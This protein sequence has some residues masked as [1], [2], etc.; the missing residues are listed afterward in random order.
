[1]DRRVLLVDDDPAMLTLL[2]K[3]L[4][5]AEYEVLTARDGQSALQLLHR[6]GPPIVLSDWSMPGMNGLELCQA[7]RASEAIGFVYLI[8]LTANS[9]KDRV[10]EALEAGANDF[11]AK[12]F[13]HQEL[14]A[15]LNAGMRI[16]SLEAD[17]KR[18][19]RELHKANAELAILNR[20]LEVMATTDELTGLAN[21]REAM[22]QLKAGW[23]ACRQKDQPFSCIM[24]DIDHFKECNDTYGHDAGD[25]VLRQTAGLLKRVARAGDLVCR[26]GGEEFLV[27]C[28]NA[29]EETALQTAHRLLVAIESNDI[30]LAGSVLRITISAGVAAPGEHTDTAEDLLKSADQAL[31]LA[32]HGGRNRVVA[33]GG[34]LSRR[35]P[36]SLLRA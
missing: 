25:E 12:P 30:H 15:R 21:R 20:K 16:I 10:V 19:Q 3:Y 36:E 13:H 26:F 24:L 34:G 29:G 28:P 9:D 7:I 22:T 14:L 32:K 11:L 31:Y 8:M 33:S 18:Q 17:L 23:A 1:M 2:S 4:A 5:R 6:E 35:G 27:L